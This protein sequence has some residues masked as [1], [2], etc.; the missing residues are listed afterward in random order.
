MIVVEYVAFNVPA[1]R[2]VADPDLA[3]KFLTRVCRSLPPELQVDLATF[4]KTLLNLR[5]R[6]EAKRGLPRLQRSYNGR[7]RSKP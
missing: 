2:I 1:G 7:G 3:A 4:N 5:R 6:D